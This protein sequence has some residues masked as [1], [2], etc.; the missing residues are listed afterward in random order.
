MSLADL[1]AITIARQSSQPSREGFGQPLICAYHLHN[2]DR[3]RSYTSLDALVGDGFKS[4]SPTYRAMQTMFS[5]SPRP[6][7]VKVGR[8]ASPF[9]QVFRFVPTAPSNAA[10]PEAYGVKVDGLDAAYTTDTTG[11]LAEVCTNLA[12]AINALADVDAILATGGASTAGE[13]TLTTALN[14]AVGRATMH[15]ARA[16]TITLSSH[17]D[18]NETTATINGVDVDGRVVSDTFAL[19]DG[20]NATVA[21]T[22]AT[23]FAKVTSVVIPIQGGTGGTFTVGTRAPVTADGTSGTH[24]VCTAPVAGELH[25][26][27][28]V[29]TNVGLTDTSADPGIA[30]DLAAI[31][32][33]DS[34][35]YGLVLD[36]QSEAEINAAAAWVETSSKLMVVQTADLGCGVAA[37][38][39]DVMSDL[40][41]A[42]YART[43]AWFYPA[44]AAATGWLAAGILANRLPRDPGSDTW[45]FKTLPGV[46]ARTLSD[47]AHT[48]ILGKNGNTY[49]VVGGVA[50]TYP[51]KVAAGEWCDIVR[52]IDWLKARLREGVFGVQVANEKVAFTD[53]GIDLYATR[54]RSVFTEGVRVGLIADSPKFTVSAP[55]AVNV[56]VGNRTARHLPGVTGAARVA[57]AIHTL[58]LVVNLAD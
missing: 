41:L 43:S 4:D 32:A 48:G 22:S 46:T 34:D 23:R 54:I 29:T 18:W 35:W 21:G 16:L 52:G 8:R 40:K 36:S 37:T 27:E 13:Q 5:Q 56:T 28:L 14:G 24:I 25:A 53:G 26:A 49:E 31:L 33:A 47:T 2:I 12:L 38:T 1:V 7:R 50:I 3:V 30:A 9:T 19:P 17:A 39:T 44:I 58:D 51:G 42:S 55:R 11:S 45:A 15:P 6:S 10:I 20:G 57:G